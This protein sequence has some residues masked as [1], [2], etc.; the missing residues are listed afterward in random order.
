MALRSRRPGAVRSLAAV[1]ALVAFLGTGCA[2]PVNGSPARSP[3]SAVPTLVAPTAQVLTLDGVARH[4][5]EPGCVV[6]DAEDHGLYLLLGAGGR[7]PDQ[8]AIPLGVPLRLHGIRVDQ[9]VSY[10]QQGTPLE[11]QDVSRR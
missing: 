5:V 8:G 1:T 10:C 6:F 3:R 4:G 2:Q 9:L 7:T 11:V